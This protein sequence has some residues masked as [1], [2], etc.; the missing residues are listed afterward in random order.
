MKTQWVKDNWT[1]VWNPSKLRYTIYYKYMVFAHKDKF[2][3]CEPYL[4]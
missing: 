2:S 1:V 3:Q 4:R